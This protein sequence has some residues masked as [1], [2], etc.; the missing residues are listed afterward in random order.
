MGV[1]E[2]L[3][4]DEEWKAMKEHYSEIEGVVT[5]AQT[6]HV[7]GTGEMREV[8]FFKLEGGEQDYYFT[9]TA[10]MRLDNGY[11]VRGLAPVVKGFVSS[12]EMGI[13]EEGLFAETQLGDITVKAVPFMKL[14][15]YDKQDGKLLHSYLLT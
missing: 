13:L 4:G 11:F 8:T 7:P 9:V 14:D 6:I 15:I 10:Q 1:I 5:E 3:L 2:D 12:E